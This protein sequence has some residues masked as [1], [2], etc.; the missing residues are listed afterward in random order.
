MLEAERRSER[1]KCQK[2]EKKIF[3]FTI[4]PE[5]VLNSTD[6]DKRILYVFR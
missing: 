1:G 6:S 2:K 3:Y 5:L 4:L